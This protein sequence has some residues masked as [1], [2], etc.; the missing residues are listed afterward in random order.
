MHWKVLASILLL[1]VLFGL[2]GCIQAVNND[3]SEQQKRPQQQNK[4]ADDSPSPHA[5]NE[6]AKSPS[7]P[8]VQDD[9]RLSFQCIGIDDETMLAKNIENQQLPRPSPPV[10]EAPQPRRPAFLRAVTGD[11]SVYDEQVRQMEL[12]IAELRDR[13]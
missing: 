1:V 5:S 9:R 13:K 11:T 3:S 2:P 7:A 8:A 12:R 4:P 6:K 10:I